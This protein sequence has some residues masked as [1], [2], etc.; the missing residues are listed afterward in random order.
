MPTYRLK[1]VLRFVDGQAGAAFDTVEIG[2]DGPDEAI[3]LAEQYQ[4][5]KARMTLSV[6]VLTDQTGELIWS[7]RAPDH[8]DAE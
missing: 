4:C 1:C 6:A 8:V 5:S 7:L 3:A 2:A